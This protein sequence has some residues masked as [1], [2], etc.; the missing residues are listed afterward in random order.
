MRSGQK[1]HAAQTPCS[2]FSG[3]GTV[4][5]AFSLTNQ[6]QFSIHTHSYS[7]TIRSGNHVLSVLHTAGRVSTRVWT[8]G[9]RDWTTN[10]LIT[11]F[12][13]LKWPW[14][15]YSSP[16][17]SPSV[18]AICACVHELN[19]LAVVAPLSPAVCPVHCKHRACTKDDQC[20]HDQCLG[21]CLKPNST[22]H[23]VACRGLQHE[24]NCVE[25]CPEDHFTYKGWRCVS[26][27]FCQ[28]LH[29]RCKREKE[30]NKSPDC[31]EYVIH[32]GACIPECPS[33]YTT[34]NSSS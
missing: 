20:C 17:S 34:V 14:A 12:C 33:G 22:S 6:L 9:V 8:A 27:A 5:P 19:N 7:V 3:M 2:C 23:C 13:H 10:L 29:S 28:D 15:L 26:F 25:R 32:N 18:P 16:C 31:Q 11:I 24:G 1:S 30:R 4:L 21:G